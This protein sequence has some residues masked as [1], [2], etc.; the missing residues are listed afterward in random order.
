MF[1]INSIFSS[2][3]SV[4]V[5]F[6]CAESNNRFL[7]LS[8]FLA[9][10][11]LRL[12]APPWLFSSFRAK[13]VTSRHYNYWIIRSCTQAIP[14]EELIHRS[15]NVGRSDKL[16]SFHNSSGICTFQVR[17]WYASSRWR[18][19]E[20]GWRQGIREALGLGNNFLLKHFKNLSHKH[21]NKVL[22]YSALHV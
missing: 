20:D 21:W 11:F 5:C 7:T 16:S 18:P 14:P 6:L 1:L 4:M 22:L 8:A 19:W 12:A 15:T 13:Y 10:D 3:I 2:F 9:S 17:M